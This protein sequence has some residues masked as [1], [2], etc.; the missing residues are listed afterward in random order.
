MRA[1]E[2]E[3][4]RDAS[5]QPAADKGAALRRRRVARRLSRRDVADALG[6]AAA[7]VDRWEQGRDWPDPATER[8]WR[9]ALG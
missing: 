6:L 9:E 8:R 4:D 7:D 5:P 1:A 3:P 2:S